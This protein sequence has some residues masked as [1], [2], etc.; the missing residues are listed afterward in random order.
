[1]QIDKRKLVK[2]TRFSSS[3]YVGDP[4]NALKIFNEKEVD[5]IAVVDVGATRNKTGPDLD[6]IKTMAGEC[7]MPLAYGGG[8]NS[9]SQAKEIFQAGVEKL[10]I[11][12]AAFLNPALVTE[13]SSHYGVQSVMVSVDVKKDFFGRWKVYVCS[14]RTKT[15]FT[16]VEYAK[17]VEGN[18]A[19]EILLQSIDREGT[20]EGYDLEMIEQVAGAVNIPV[21]PLGGAASLEDFLQA[22]RRGASAIAAGDMFIYKGPHKAVLI[23]Y[24]SQNDLIEKL[25][26]RI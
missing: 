13:I 15:N 24:P 9:F 1:L 21:V 2:T 11:G 25:Y 17:F 22:V 7:F 6:N 12:E 3:S 16:P 26:K 18:G 4:I 23:N 14:G 20:Q 19:G 10:I 8:I 5:E